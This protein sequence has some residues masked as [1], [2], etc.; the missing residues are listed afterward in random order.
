MTEKQRIYI[1]SLLSELGCSVQFAMDECFGRPQ[2][3]HMGVKDASV[4]IG[5]LLEE[6]RKGEKR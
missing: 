1:Q 2:P 6:K 3:K 5:W 4:F